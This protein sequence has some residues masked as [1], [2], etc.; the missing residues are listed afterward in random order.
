[1]E[2][3]QG[4]YLLW[5]GDDIH[6]DRPKALLLGVYSSERAA[7]DRIDQAVLLPGFRDRPDDFQISCHTIDKD[8]WTSGYT[9]ISPPGVK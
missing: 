3:Q 9:E 4:V 5:H 8:E 7:H 2:S 6:D 1:M